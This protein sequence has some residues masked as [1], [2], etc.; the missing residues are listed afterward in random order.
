MPGLF[1]NQEFP[2]KYQEEALALLKEILGSLKNIDGGIQRLQSLQLEAVPE[3]VATPNTIQIIADLDNQGD[4]DELTSQITQLQAELKEQVE[5][6][7]DQTRWLYEAREDLQSALNRKE[8]LK[9]ELVRKREEL[10][11]CLVD[12]ADARASLA[13]KEKD[14]Q[15]S[16]E[17][18][19]AVNSRLEQMQ[20]DL[21]YARVEAQAEYNTLLEIKDKELEH[22]DNEIKEFKAALEQKDKKLHDLT[23]ELTEASIGLEARAREL[24]SCLGDLADARASLLPEQVD[25]LQIWRKLQ[26]LPQSVKE[27]IA[28]YYNPN[29]LSVFLTQCGQFALLRECWQSCMKKALNGAKIEGMADFLELVL[30]IYNRAFA[31]NPCQLITAE[32]ESAFDITEQDRM[33]PMGDYVSKMLLPGLIKP[34]GEIACKCLVELA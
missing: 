25:L 1:S 16:L 19:A 13:Q 30:Q 33:G 18:L 28:L 9:K 20:N 22:K 8:E 2:D 31:D 6:Y 29:E 4:Q 27:I 24:D 17:T 34:N 21:S 23:A 15:E 7:H 26:N 14:L 10:D 3:P 5:L 12:L 32:P 11:S